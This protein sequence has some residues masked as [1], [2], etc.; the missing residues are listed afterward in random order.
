MVIEIEIAS[1]AN[2][3]I[4]MP[5]ET[6]NSIGEETNIISTDIMKGMITEGRTTKIKKEGESF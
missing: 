1:K 4:T 5:K 2:S 6:I 3:L